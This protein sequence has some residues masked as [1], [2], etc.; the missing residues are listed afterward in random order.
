MFFYCLEIKMNISRKS[1]VLL[2]PTSLPGTYGIGT[3]GKA[4]YQFVDWLKDAGQS[5][6]QILPLGPTGYGDSPYAS[7]ST[8][9]GNPLLID[10]DLLVEKGWCDKKTIVPAEYIKKTGNVDFGSVVWWKTPILKKAALYFLENANKEDKKSYKDFC[11][12]KSS[13]L[14]M[15]AIFMSIKNFY[16]AKAEQ[17]KPANSIW[18][19]YWPKGLAGCQKEELEEW[20][21][22]HNEEIEVY[23]VIQF[24][25]E[26]Q[27]Q[28]LKKYANDAGIKIIGDIPIFV[29]PDSAD[30]WSN[31][32]FFQLD[33]DGHPSCVAGVPPDYFSADGQLWGNP[34]YDWDSLKESG[35]SWWIARIKRIFE[36]TDILRIDHFRGFEAYWAVPAGEKTAMN[37]KSIKGPGIDLFKAIKKKLGDLPIIAEDL[38]VITDEVK[39]L[40]DKAGLPG[41]KVL[42]FAYSVDE[43]KQNGMV[44]Y[45]MPH[46]YDTN[47]CVVYTGTHDNDTLQ[48]WLENCG[49]EQIA[50][51][52]SYFEGKEIEPVKAKALVKSGQLRKD[53]IKSALSSTAVF[54]V[55]PM[56]DIIG[57]GNEARMNT[58]STTG[59]NWAWRMQTG[60]LKTKA[61][62]ELKFLA[63]LYGRNL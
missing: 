26:S 49:D 3:I 13:W 17:E 15:F 32:K 24:F 27:W 7:F 47:N 1:G 51:I 52:A 44:N 39:E 11:K 57:L 54:A 28:A 62:E 29:A 35:Y 50:M 31:Q 20:K 2:H 45:F 21:K 43:V 48:G 59:A 41:M 18:H 8:F 63:A 30:V 25:F 10:L 61:A 14:D 22:G 34:L 60:Q 16:D 42:E 58:P 6:W 40:R 46:M 23:K 12:E 33:K 4:A 19:C 55:I 37:G 56:Q 5:L 36:L 53:F 38:G 9:A